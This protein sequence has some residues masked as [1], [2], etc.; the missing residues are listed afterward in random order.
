MRRADGSDARQ[1]LASI[2]RL[3]A[4][5]ADEQ[6]RALG[7]ALGWL[8]GSG[9]VLFAGLPGGA[10]ALVVLLA[11]SNL[12]QLRHRL[13][14]GGSPRLPTSRGPSSTSRRKRSPTRWQCCGRGMQR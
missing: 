1:L 9:S 3:L 2:G 14:K 11:L 8:V 7:L 5:A 6:L 12:L 4:T 10:I 13:K